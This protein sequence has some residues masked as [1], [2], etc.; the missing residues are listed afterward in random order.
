MVDVRFIMVV[1]E[2]DEC[3]EISINDVEEDNAQVFS[4][5][6]CADDLYFC[7]QELRQVL[8]LLNFQNNRI[9]ELLNR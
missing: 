6:V 7:K 9:I 1:Q 8:D 5:N 4:W 3:F 2:L